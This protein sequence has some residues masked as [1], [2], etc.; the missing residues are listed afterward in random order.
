MYSGVGDGFNKIKSSQGLGGFTLGWLP[1]LVGY[2]AQGFGKFG[3]Y[4]IFKDVYRTAA[5]DNEPKY[6]TVGF[7]LSSACAEFIAD[8]LLCPWEAVSTQFEHSKS[9]FSTNECL[10]NNYK[11]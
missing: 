4:E 8:I 5:G 3:F 10:L 1:T 2:S 11:I 6:R 7:A 9:K